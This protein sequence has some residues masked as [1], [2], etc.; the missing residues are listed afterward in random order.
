[1]KTC[2]LVLA[3]AALGLAVT[4]G[5]P[6]PAR[7]AAMPETLTLDLQQHHPEIKGLPG[8]KKHV[9]GF[10]HAAHADKYVPANAAYAAHPIKNGLS[11]TACHPSATSREA[12]LAD[13]PGT[14][15][16][17]DMKAAGGVKKVKKYFHKLCR[18][19][20][21]AMKKAGKAT[22]PTNCKGC[23]GRK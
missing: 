8:N 10:A 6:S 16:A 20:H 3:A 5:G 2:H 15:L 21:Q 19:C 13:D 1:M 23:H 11:C 7:A 12:L 18:S 17:A 22:G 14:R 4:T 9:A